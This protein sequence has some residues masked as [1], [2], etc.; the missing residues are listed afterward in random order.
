MALRKPEFLFQ[1]PMERWTLW[2]ACNP[3]TPTVRWKLERGKSPETYGPATL[4]HILVNKRCSLRQS[5]NQGWTPEVVLWSLHVCHGIHMLV[6]TYR[7]MHIY[8]KTHNHPHTRKIK[9]TRRVLVRWSFVCISEGFLQKG[10]NEEGR[11]LLN[12]DSA[13]PWLRC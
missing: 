7:S 8:V 9:E 5:G 4:A 1:E 2:C 12:L 3:R 10:L 6:H 13:I 11:H